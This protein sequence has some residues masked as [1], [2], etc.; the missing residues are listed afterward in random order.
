MLQYEI[1]VNNDI[2]LMLDRRVP[3]LINLNELIVLQ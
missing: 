1:K 2:F 3:V